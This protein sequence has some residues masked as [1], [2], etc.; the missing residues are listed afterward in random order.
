MPLTLEIVLTLGVLGVAIVALMT[1]RA[2]ADLILVGALGVLIVLDELLPGPSGPLV[3]LE[4][5]LKGF[6]NPG[7]LTVGVMF[8]VAEGLQQTG[9][10]GFWVQQFLGQPKSRASAQWRMMIPTAAMS[11]FMN[12][13]PVVA[14]LMP[15][16]DE[17]AKKHRLA[18]S[19]LMLPL[20]YAAIFGGLC[21]LIGTSTTL[22]VDGMM[23]ESGMDGLS[24][25]E[26]APVGLPCCLVG[27][28]Y[29]LLTSKWLLPNR[30]PVIDQFDNP[31]EYTVEMLVEPSSPLVG[32]TIE[33]AGLRHLPGMFLMEIEREGRIVPAVGPREVLQAGDRLV[34]VG[35]VESVVDLQRIPGLKPAT[36]QVF[37]LDSPRSER[38]LIEAV[39]SD[40][41]PVANMTIREARFRTRYNAV[42]IAVARNGQR[43]PG[44]IGSIQL[45][46]G[47][48]LLL[49][50]HPTFADVQRN[51]RD[52]YLVS[53]IENSNPPRHEQ[54]WIALVILSAMVIAVALFDVEMLLAS[55]AAA[56]A[57]IGLRCVH[58]TEARRSID[59]SVLVTIAAGIGLGAAVEES[60]TA[61]YIAGNLIGLAGKN[62]TL[63]LAIIYGLTMVFTNLITAKAAAGVIFYIAIQ[64]ADT[65]QTSPVPFTI[66]VIIASAAS[67]AT[68]MGYQ[69]N[70][71]VFGPG[72]Y[73]YLDYVR[74][75]GPL[76]LL[77]WA[78]S[79]AVIPLVWPFHP[80]P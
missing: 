56:A 38:C 70:M 15:V 53:R 36:N 11:A 55:F 41:C 3:S 64:T 22:V 9:A 48:T 5:A 50:A 29:V 61:H 13:T 1:S 76:S 33:G 16:L 47:D 35:V 72:G 59:W 4:G 24:M 30:K 66:A 20:S 58:G 45:Q 34:F 31:R 79:I 7:M 44:K 25:F 73:R 68:P 40:T 2:G 46:A 32:R 63:A 77:L 51:S 17:W 62:E 71:M 80:L 6:A 8:V 21:T 27:L 19:H 12:N 57:M 37:K 10:V 74:F 49:E 26:L 14:I 43:L 28:A 23:R 67:F 65:L 54:A 18:V 78:V 75:G 69:T 60:G 42:V 39:V 52:F